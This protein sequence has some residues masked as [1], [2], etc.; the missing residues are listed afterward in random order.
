MSSKPSLLS[1]LHRANQ[2]AEERFTSAVG[3]TQVTARQLQV[4]AAIDAMPGASQVDLT[5][6]TS[7]D[8]STMA[9][10]IRRLLLR[11]LVQRRRSK[12]DARAYTISLTNLGDAALANGAPVLDSIEQSLLAV[13]S[14]QQR[15]EFQTMLAKIIAGGRPQG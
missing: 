14:V 6:T 1:L 5:D 10:M 12:Q 13:L 2:L 4:L 15:A 9:D 11:K 7:I 8:R 3:E